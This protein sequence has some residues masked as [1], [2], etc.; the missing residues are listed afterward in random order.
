MKKYWKSI[1]GIVL[2]ALGSYINILWV[3][4]TILGV[5]VIAFGSLFL[6]IDRVKSNIIVRKKI[7]EFSGKL[8]A[9]VSTQPL[10]PEISEIHSEFDDWAKDYIHR[11]G[12]KKIEIAEADLSDEKLKQELN[13]EWENCYKSCINVI[14]NISI[15]VKQNIN[16]NIEY[17]IPNLPQSIYDKDFYNYYAKIKFNEDYIWYISFAGMHPKDGIPTINLSVIDED[18]K[19][20]EEPLTFQLNLMTYVEI[21]FRFDIHEK[22]FSMNRTYRKLKTKMKDTDFATDEIEIAFATIFKEL[23]DNQLALIK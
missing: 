10:I 20:D 16:S 13:D 11:V 22:K 4:H 23:F 19:R 3:E 21:T 17:D 1:L 6:L 9:A 18:Y 15:S 2:I 7:E 5:I 12:K 8:D 14:R